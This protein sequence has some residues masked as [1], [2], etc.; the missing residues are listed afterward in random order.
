MSVEY[1]SSFCEGEGETAP[2]EQNW[3]GFATSFSSSITIASEG[4]APRGLRQWIAYESPSCVRVKYSH[5]PQGT[6][7]DSSVSL[8]CERNSS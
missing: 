4:S 1:A 6:G 2:V 3:N 8:M 7:A 5:S